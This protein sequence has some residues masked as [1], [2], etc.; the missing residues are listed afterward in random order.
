MNEHQF[1]LIPQPVLLYE[2]QGGSVP[3]QNEGLTSSI[4]LADA[5]WQSGKADG[6]ALGLS[7]TTLSVDDFAL[8]Q[9]I[10]P[11]A[12][13]EREEGYLLAVNGGVIIGADTEAGAFYAVQTLAQLLYSC[14]N[15]VL[16]GLYAADWPRLSLR[17]FH[18]CYHMVSEFLPF[19]APNLPMMLESV[20]EMAHYKMNAVLL[21][22][23]AM[24]PYRRY[25]FLSVKETFT[26]EQIEKM[27][28]CCYNNHVEII[29]LIQCLG[30]AYNVL[31]HPEFAHLRETP[32]TTHQYCPTNPETA[33]LF[34]ELA[35]EQIELLGG[36]RYFLMGGDEARRLGY[37]PACAKKKKDEGLGALY[38]DY[39]SAA[40]QPLLAQG[41]TPL[42]WSDIIEAHEDI[43]AHLDPRIGLVYWNYDLAQ[44]P[45]TYAMEKFTGTERL[46]LGASASRFGGHPDYMF[47]YK[48][49]MRGISLMAAEC[50]RNRAGGVMVTNWTKP[51]PYEITV[52]AMA[53]GAESAWGQFRD[54]QSFAA[55]FS[56]LHFG[57]EIPEMDAIYDLLSEP[58][59]PSGIIGGNG[60]ALPFHDSYYEDMTDKL[61]RY[62]HSGP[63]FL[64]ALI[65]YNK[66]DNRSKTETLQK[67]AIVRAQKAECLLEKYAGRVTQKER[68][69]NLLC[70]AAKVMVL[71]SRVGLAFLEAVRLLK[72]PQPCEE[73]SREACAAEL[74]DLAGQWL[75]LR[76]S[77]EALIAPGSFEAGMETVLN[78]KFDPE[79]VRYMRAYADLL[80]KGKQMQGI[81]DLRVYL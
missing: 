68:S 64:H 66:Q 22:F 77:C 65:E 40:A 75:T 14:K 17:C 2:T 18:V 70:H 31:R 23:E 4:E 62:D 1:Y 42:V 61:D 53:W 36:V 5:L 45:R 72:Y 55:A 21:E 46:T 25:P 48:K 43:E 50:V 10:T 79:A 26:P 80:K 6:A 69:Y 33:R 44:W 15:G 54:Q 32:D 34:G 38:G 58:P 3:F 52:I 60:G 16:P 7:I 81:A 39:V 49:A 27:R 24:F 76:K 51:T 11:P 9:G 56:L 41:I 37:C 30:H 59:L 19:M 29:P 78:A 8:R 73:K 71:K 20:R 67:E 74:D 13:F 12:G 57:C 28:V 47:L 63:A 35:R